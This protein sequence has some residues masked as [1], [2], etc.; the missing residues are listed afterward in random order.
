MRY[1]YKAIRMAEW[2]RWKQMLVRMYKMGRPFTYCGRNVKWYICWRFL[3][4]LKLHLHMAQHVYSCAFVP[5]KPRFI[6][7]KN[8][9]TNVHA[10]FLH[11]NPRLEIIQM[12][13]NWLPVRPRWH[14][15][16]CT[17]SNVLRLS[18]RNKLLIHRNKLL[19]WWL[20]GFQWDCTEEKANPKCHK[21]SYSI[22]A[23]V[24]DGTIIEMESSLVVARCWGTGGGSRGLWKRAQGV[25]EVGACGI[26][27]VMIVTPILQMY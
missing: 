6:F 24:S 14:I 10:K 3:T 26:L 9:Y 13:F 2:K 12:S 25:F 27:T 8:L 5:E 17:T 20:D 1:Y 23:K 16:S 19:I 18:D 21:L 4:E 22:Y 11:T 7:T 15:H